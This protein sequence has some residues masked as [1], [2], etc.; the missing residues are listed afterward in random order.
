MSADLGFRVPAPRGPADDDVLVSPFED[1]C[2]RVGV[3][4]EAI[5][6]WDRFTACST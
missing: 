1:W 5:D 3:D 4:P 6:A 2:Q